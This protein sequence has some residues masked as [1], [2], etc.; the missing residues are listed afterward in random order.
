MAWSQGDGQPPDPRINKSRV[1]ASV[2]C[3]QEEE[4]DGWATVGSTQ[5]G[6]HESSKPAMTGV[7]AGRHEPYR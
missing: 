7:D 3:W 2:P 5:T 6:S 4:R 1:S